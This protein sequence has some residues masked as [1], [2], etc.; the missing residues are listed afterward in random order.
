[1]GLSISGVFRY[2]KMN[3]NVEPATS[4]TAPRSTA[5]SLAS[6]LVM[7]Q[8]Q[9]RLGGMIIMT[10]IVIYRILYRTRMHELQLLQEE[11]LVGLVIER[12]CSYGVNMTLRSFN[13]SNYLGLSEG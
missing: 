1:M 3:L 6:S 2:A 4:P 10:I 12:M 5:T 13:Y 8:M 9:L 11:D 7:S